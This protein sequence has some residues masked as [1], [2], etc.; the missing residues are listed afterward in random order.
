MAFWWVNHNQTF[1]EE[2][3]GGLIW[4]PKTDSDGS[5]NESYINLTKCKPADLVFSYSRQKIGAVGIVTAPAYESAQPSEFGT[6]G[7]QWHALG[8]A[9]P[10]KWTIVENPFAPKDHIQEIA[11]LLPPKHSPIRANGVGNQGCYLAGISDELGAKILNYLEGSNQLLDD[12]L[13]DGVTAIEEDIQQD[14]I[15]HSSIAETEKQQLVL[16][17]RGQGVFRQRLEDV[18]T[19]C[20]I[21]GIS[22][23]RVLVASHIMPWKVSNNYERLDGY[24]GFLLSPHVDKLFDKGWISFSDSGEL[25]VSSKDIFSILLAWSIPLEQNVGKFTDQQRSY[26]AYHRAQIFKK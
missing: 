3:N 6:K 10:I 7:R 9:V 26:L 23:K 16:A 25:L 14:N 15:S 20:R 22:D 19:R 11:P 18:E 17:R 4:S 8:W 1:K 24:N 21:T 5:K 13:T 2:I 12:Q